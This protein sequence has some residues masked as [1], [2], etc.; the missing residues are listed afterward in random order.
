M[1]ESSG[2]VPIEP[3]VRASAGDRAL[4]EHLTQH[5]QIESGLLEEYARLAEATESKALAYVVNLL[6]EDERRHHRLFT[7]LA[8]SLKHEADLV[9]EEPVV[10]RMDFHRADRAAV[11]DVTGRLLAREREDAREL[12]QLRKELRDYEDTTLWSL[13]VEL[14]QRDTDKHIA[15]LRFAQHSTKHPIA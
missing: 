3:P 14:M 15:M 2:E 6:L 12:K 1:S 8:E 9:A 7:E 4:F 5:L 11:L 10:P 13:L